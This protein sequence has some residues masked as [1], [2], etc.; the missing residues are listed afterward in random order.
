[1]GPLCLIVFKTPLTPVV[2]GTQLPSCEGGKLHLSGAPLLGGTGSVRI[3]SLALRR[4]V[5]LGRGKGILMVI[6]VIFSDV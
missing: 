1:M 2:L 5:G 3:F 6:L 4:F